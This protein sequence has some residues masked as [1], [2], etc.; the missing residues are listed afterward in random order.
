VTPQWLR[1]L[2]HLNIATHRDVGYFVSALVI[3]YCL[4]GLALNHVDV[5]NPDFVIHKRRVTIE[6]RVD[7]KLTPADI[8]AYGRLVDEQHYRVYDF[9][10]RDQVK[11]YYE[12]ATLHLDLAAGTGLY[13]RVTRRPLF[14]QVN[15]LHRNSFKPWKW[16]AD[17]F[18]VLL[19]LVNITGMFVLRGKQGLGGRG[20]WLIAAGALS[21]IIA[22]VLHN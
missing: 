20:K 18:A 13:E 17:G 16:A 21:P 12:T 5:W 22:L 7:A 14:Y 4:S 10:T 1:D 2:R 15:V 19:L 6:A 9:P 11:I 8:E 3:A